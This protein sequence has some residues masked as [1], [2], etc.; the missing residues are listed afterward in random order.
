[1]ET[2]SHE[3]LIRFACFA[4][5]LLLMALWEALAPRRRLT[6]SRPVRWFS[7]LGLVALDT[8]AVRFLVPLGAVGVAV[9]AGE[10]GWGLLNNVALPGWLAVALS[11][12]ALDLAIYLQHLMFHAVPLLWRL[13][14]VHHADLD[15]DAST[16]VRF[17]TLEILLSVLIKMG[18]VV[19]LG[20]PALGVVIFEVLLNATSLFSHGNV[21]LPGWLDRPL[22]LAV[23]TPE[24]HR[25]HHSA[26]PRET[27]SNFGFNLPWWDYLFGTYR[28]RP[29]E[30][31]EGMTVGLSQFRDERVAD[32][33]HWMLLLPFV[34]RPGGYPITRRGETDD[35][36]Q[37][38][39]EGPLPKGA[40]VGTKGGHAL[41]PAHL[42][43]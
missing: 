36:P 23:V 20:A 22:R 15:F 10:R 28:A 38:P 3:P 24:M 12:V 41:G 8:L 6:V 19:L 18:V 37:D 14:M 33:L 17:H 29:A 11:V 35:P 31:H 34:G 13:H 39:L 21:R 43:R 40:S 25:V 5:V 26:E 30:G 1:M 4:G 16:G 7:N 9:L 27:N 42:P 32:R 2:L